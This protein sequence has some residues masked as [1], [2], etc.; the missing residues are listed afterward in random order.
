MDWRGHHWFW[1][2]RMAAVS[3]AKALIQIAIIL[4]V[5]LIGLGFGALV[6]AWILSAVSNDN[7][8]W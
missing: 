4:L 5:M 6:L 8:E 3:I 7:G 2:R 1:H